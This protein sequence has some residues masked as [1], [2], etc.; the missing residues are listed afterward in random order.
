M[1]TYV[2][3]HVSQC[4]SVKVKGQFGQSV[5]SF[6]QVRSGIEFKSTGLVVKYSFA[7][8]ELFLPSSFHLLSFW[9][10]G[11]TEPRQS[12]SWF[13]CVSA[14]VLAWNTIL[15]FFAFYFF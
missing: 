15:S 8:L 10:L 7:S 13:P 4:E 5:F 9:R 14:C 2:G 12:L 6:Y 1:C 11:L 3:T